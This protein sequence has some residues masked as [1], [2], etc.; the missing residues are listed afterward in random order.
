MVT[1]YIEKLV[2]PLGK[3]MKAT[4]TTEHVLSQDPFSRKGM[5][6][7]K[8]GAMDE[9]DSSSI[10]RRAGQIQTKATNTRR[11]CCFD[12]GKA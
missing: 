9:L 1:V 7:Q 11:N 3:R 12:S 5:I 6:E 10:T 8:S 4:P 2:T